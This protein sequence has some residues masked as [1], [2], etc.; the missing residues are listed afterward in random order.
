MKTHVTVSQ[1]T[2]LKSAAIVL[3]YCL[4]KVIT[5]NFDQKMIILNFELDYS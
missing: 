5:K 2:R 3:S 1:T 4:E